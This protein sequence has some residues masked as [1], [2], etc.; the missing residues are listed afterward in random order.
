MN[1]RGVGF[2]SISILVLG[3]QA[4]RS[5]LSLSDWR[6]TIKE[7]EGVTV[8]E[9]PAEPLYAPDVF[10]IDEELSI[11]GA[12]TKNFTISNI[13]EF[14]ID[15]SEN[16]LVV[17]SKEACIL[18]FD[19]R[20]MFVRTIGRKGQGPGEFGFPRDLIILPN[21]DIAVLDSINRRITYFSESGTFR[22]SVSE[23]DFDFPAFEISP[24]GV[25]VAMD[26]VRE[27][28]SRRHEIKTYTPELKF[29]KSIELRSYPRYQEIES[30][31]AEP[32][33][34]GQCQGPD[35][36]RLSQLLRIQGLLDRRKA[37]KENSQEIRS[38]GNSR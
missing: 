5:N 34:R 14:E 22:K 38:P 21:K 3:I 19:K 18:V 1:V 6:G 29:I 7:I 13:F 11:G 25:I 32:G 28:T 23:V 10:R 9:N 35:R 26:I 16:M 31:H 15:G 36:L 30:I 37:H 2:L 27:E 17:D 4:S 20:G 33:F 24:T 8:V 12:A